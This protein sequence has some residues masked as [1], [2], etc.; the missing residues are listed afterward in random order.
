MSVVMCLYRNTGAN[1]WKPAENE[2]G[3]HQSEQAL[4]LV[5][6]A[7]NSFHTKTPQTAEIM[8]LPSPSEN[9]VA[10]PTKECRRQQSYKRSRFPDETA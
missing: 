5:A 2:E 3:E 6:G 7:R 8:V 9:E 10:G 4:H 1:E